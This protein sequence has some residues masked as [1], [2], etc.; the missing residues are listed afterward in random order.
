MHHIFI[1]HL[2]FARSLGLP[3]FVAIVNRRT[4]NTGVSG[5]LL[6]GTDIFVYTSRSGIAISHG[7][8]NF[9]CYMNLFQ[10]V[11]YSGYTSLYSHQE[12]RLFSSPPHLQ[13]MIQSLLV[14]HKRFIFNYVWVRASMCQCM[15]IGISRCQMSSNL[16]EEQFQVVINHFI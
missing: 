10:P 8:S 6:Q 4:M 13:Q 14:I 5:S 3:H 11:F 16:L 15:S 7:R 2:S 12:Q 9:T 1:A